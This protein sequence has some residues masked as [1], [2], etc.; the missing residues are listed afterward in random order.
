MLSANGIGSFAELDRYY[1]ECVI[2]G[3]GA[4]VLVASSPDELARTI[5][6]KLIMEISGLAPAARVVPAQYQPMD[7]LIG[8][9]QYRNR[10]IYFR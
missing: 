6:R 5:R 8:E 3:Q 10:G 1:E 7:C 2:G 9:K 4:F